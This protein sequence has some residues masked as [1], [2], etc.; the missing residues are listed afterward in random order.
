[1][2]LNEILL[3][4]TICWSSLVLLYFYIKF[5]RRN[6]PTFEQVL[7]LCGESSEN[8][9]LLFEKQS[10]YLDRKI[11]DLIQERDKLLEDYDEPDKTFH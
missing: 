8:L 4:I 11:A 5:K 6:L 9:S 3:L 10:E 7:S 2:N 1:M